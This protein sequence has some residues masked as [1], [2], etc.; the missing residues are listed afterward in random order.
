MEWYPVVTYVLE[1]GLLGMDLG[2]EGV[3]SLAVLLDDRVALDLERRCHL[4]VLDRECF[5]LNQNC[6]WNLE[7]TP[8]RKKAVDV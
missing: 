6:L 8:N 7:P 5:W 3:Q 1:L 2:I 4:V